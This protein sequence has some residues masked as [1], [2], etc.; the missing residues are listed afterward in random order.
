MDLDNILKRK[1]RSLS[2]SNKSPVKRKPRTSE[3]IHKDNVRY[4]IRLIETGDFN[5][6]KKSHKILLYA[7][8]KSGH[9]DRNTLE[10]LKKI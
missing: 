4:V 6:K 8:A 9:V 5:M 7:A 3:Q 1:L 10:I 2:K